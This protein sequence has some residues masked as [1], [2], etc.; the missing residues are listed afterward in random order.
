MKIEFHANDY[1]DIYMIQ[2]NNHTTTVEFGKI[3]KQ[4]GREITSFDTST[5]LYNIDFFDFMH[6]LGFNLDKMK[7]EIA[8]YLW[9]KDAFI[10]IKRYADTDVIY[11]FLNNNTEEEIAS[12]IDFTYLI[13]QEVLKKE[14]DASL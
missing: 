12:S 3:Y 8:N 1:M 11:S 13:F 9:E 4:D 2:P 14:I 10:R 5:S 7:M 6:L